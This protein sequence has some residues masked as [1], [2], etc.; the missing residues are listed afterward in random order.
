MPVKIKDGESPIKGGG[1]LYVIDGG[2]SK[3]YQKQTGI[4][5]YTFI[6]NSRFMALAQHK[7]YQP[8][9]PDGT[10]EF[11]SPEVKTVEVLPERMMVIDTD[12]GRELT[13]QVENM[14]RLVEAYRKGILKE[15][16]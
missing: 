11:Q 13:E 5:G 7:P 15:R 9:Q 3:A 10:Q 12:Q 16:Y 6:F 8:L 2:I 14:K 1:L 4:A